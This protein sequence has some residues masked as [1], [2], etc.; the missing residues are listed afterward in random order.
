MDTTDI[1][2]TSEVTTFGWVILVVVLGVIIFAV[3]R[4]VK[5][6][7]RF[8][9]SKLKIRSKI[10]TLPINNTIDDQ[11]SMSISQQEYESSFSKYGDAFNQHI[12]VRN[13][14][15]DLL[16]KLEN[17]TI[18]NFKLIEKSKSLCK[19]PYDKYELEQKLDSYSFVPEDL[20]HLKRISKFYIKPIVAVIFGTLIGAIL[21]MALLGLVS[22]FGSASTGTSI[23]SLSG[24]AETN[25]T[26]AWFGGGSLVSG[27][28]GINGGI[29][30]L[31]AVFLLPVV[32]LCYFSVNGRENNIQK[33][34]S[35]TKKLNYDDV[36]L[37]NSNRCIESEIA[38]IENLYKYIEESY[39]YTC[40]LMYPKG[41]ITRMRRG[42]SSI[43]NKDHYSNEEAKA[44]DRLAQAIYYV[45]QTSDKMR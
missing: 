33:F 39:E 43:I 14:T 36:Q 45:D 26:L 3:I 41:Y 28:D 34:K 18:H 21:V 27:G 12:D 32:A 7:R 8:K 42:L 1:A 25:A 9:L 5:S 30:A 16:K 4:R 15:N 17:T 11:A 2:T 38:H 13:Q 29:I 10:K 24:A 40:K 20:Y 22:M 6:D 44:I 31:V 23:Q 19:Q 35:E 37:R